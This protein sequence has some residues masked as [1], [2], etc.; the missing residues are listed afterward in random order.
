MGHRGRPARLLLVEDSVADAKL[1]RLA[2]EEVGSE[3]EL[4]RAH[5][6]AEALD[7]LAAVSAG[8]HPRPDVVVTDLNLPRGSGI[9]VVRRLRTDPAL[10]T[11]PVVVFSSSR[12]DVDVA[13]A[14]ECGASSYVV[15]P[16][17][18]NRFCEVVREIES[19]WASTVRLP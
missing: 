3:T 2:L 13:T 4:L 15:K 8:E 6:T 18:L 19:Y 1:F 17:D 7:L 5:D 11:I 16:L 12:D 9:D 14:Y 10:R